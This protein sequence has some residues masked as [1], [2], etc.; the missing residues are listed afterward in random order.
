MEPE[1]GES[2]DIALLRAWATANVLFSESRLPA[3]R[4]IRSYATAGL[5]S[6]DLI[7]LRLQSA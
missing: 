4:M 6:L 1:P 3:L 7:A 2:N 5:A